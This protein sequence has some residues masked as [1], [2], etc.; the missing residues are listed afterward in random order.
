MSGPILAVSDLS[1]TFGGVAALK[2]VDLCVGHGEVVAVIGPNGAG[3]STLFNALTGLAPL[4]SG[5]VQLGGAPLVRPLRRQHLLLAM[6][7]ALT[8]AVACLVIDIGPEALFE[9]AVV[10]PFEVAYVAA[11]RGDADAQALAL[12]PTRLGRLWGAWQGRPSLGASSK[13]YQVWLPQHVPASAPIRDLAEARAKAYALGDAAPQRA[14]AWR[15]L[16]SL[17]LGFAA[18][19]GAFAQLFWR[20]RRTPDHIA[21]MGLARTFQNIRLFEGLSVYDN[22]RVA[23]GLGGGAGPSYASALGGGAASALLVLASVVLQAQTNPEGFWA[24]LLLMLGLLGSVISVL[25]LARTLQ[26]GGRA[27]PKADRAM[28]LLGQVGLAHLAHAPAGALS[29]GDMRRLEIARAL[30]TR[31]RVLLLDEPAAGMN[32][33]ET[34]RLQALIRDIRASGVAVLLIEHDMPLVMNLA[35]RIV[36]LEYGQKIAD[37]PPAVVQR[38]ARVIGAYLGDALPAGMG[39][40]DVTL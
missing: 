18:G 19:L 27:A 7:V 10:R 14:H 17:A 28:A 2:N 16:G 31:P 39:E 3:K 38:D 5:T 37:G 13:G 8:A 12:E 33:T 4:S 1:V 9:E 26:A 21:R 11:S 25:A 40:A 15:H 30:A 6:A 23:E 20:S 35:D 32:A 34:H 24:G 22:V 36:V 29:Y